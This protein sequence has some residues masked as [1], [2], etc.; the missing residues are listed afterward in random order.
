MFLKCCVN[1]ARGLALDLVA[2]AHAA[3]A[4]G[5][6][7]IHAHVLD[8]RGN[9]SLDADDVAALRRAFAGPLGVSTGA[10][11]ARDRVE[12]ISRWHTL[13]DFASVNF[14]EDGAVDVAKMLFTMGVG[15]EAGL[16]NADAARIFLDSGIPCIRI[17]F[18]PE[19]PS[20]DDAL[21]NVDAMESIL[22]NLDCPRLLHGY[23]A[24]AWPLLAEA[25]PCGAHR[26]R[27]CAHA[28]GR[29]ARGVERGAGA[30]GAR[31][32]ATLSVAAMRRRES[33]R[34]AP[35]SRR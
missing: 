34:G 10:W 18:E 3:M 9:E 32:R 5:A 30:R 29:L 8:A 17:L 6:D 28:A 12:L 21:R 11:I 4:A 7:A 14:I 26:I 35:R 27:G 33:D 25:E 13:P 31:A 2:E 24:T 19:E 16:A 1:G 20:L 23:D 22:G 15:I